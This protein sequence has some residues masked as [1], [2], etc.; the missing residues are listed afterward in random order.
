MKNLVRYFAI[1][2]LCGLACGILFLKPSSLTNEPLIQGMPPSLTDIFIIDD[3]PYYFNNYGKLLSVDGN[4][5]KH[6]F[7]VGS[8]YAYATDDKI[9]YYTGST[10]YKTELDSGNSDVMFMAQDVVDFEFTDGEHFIYRTYDNKNGIMSEYTMYNTVDNSVSELNF[11]YSELIVHRIDGN[12]LYATTVGENVKRLCSFELDTG[13]K[14]SI[15]SLDAGT[16]INGVYLLGDTYYYTVSHFAKNNSTIY[17]YDLTT[18][19]TRECGAEDAILTDIIVHN[20][21]YYTI[22]GDH[23]V[24]TTAFYDK[25]S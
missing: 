17:T 4:V 24:G 18:K 12:T 9:Y 21:Y 3:N 7:N 10:F 6:A 15:F 16:K 19:T 23:M 5:L 20:G 25:L 11:G 14:T 8:N 1:S 13:K 22:A 2:L